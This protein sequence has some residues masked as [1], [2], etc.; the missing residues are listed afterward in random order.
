MNHS[1]VKS[2]LA[3][4]M[5]LFVIGVF[6]EGVYAETSTGRND[7]TV[8]QHIAGTWQLH[9]NGRI[10]PFKM[11]VKE[12]KLYFDPG[13]NELFPMSPVKD[14]PLSYTSSD[15]RGNDVK[16]IFHRD[17]DGLIKSCKVILVS[18]GIE[19]QGEKVT[20]EQENR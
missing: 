18:Q 2:V 6:P 5:V 4:M 3:A 8:G 11:V 14:E 10:M 1:V 20:E 13:M 15:P 16:W 7:E 9:A 17:T 19:A 12:K